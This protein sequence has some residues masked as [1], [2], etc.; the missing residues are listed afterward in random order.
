M[1]LLQNIHYVIPN[2]VRNL[3]KHGE[4]PSYAQDDGAA[5]TE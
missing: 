1:G 3:K 4:D 5:H 2:A